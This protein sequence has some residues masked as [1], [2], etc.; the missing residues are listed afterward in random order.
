MATTAVWADKI[1]GIMGRSR[2]SHGKQQRCWWR[3]RYSSLQSRQSRFDFES[4]TE[5]QLLVR[6]NLSLV[7]CLHV[8]TAHEELWCR[9]RGAD[10]GHRAEGCASHN[11]HV[12]LRPSHPT[13]KADNQASVAAVPRHLAT[14][15]HR[16][17]SIARVLSFLFALQAVFKSRL[18]SEMESQKSSTSSASS[19]LRGHWQTR[20]LIVHSRH[21]QG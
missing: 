4:L 15:S 5:C 17:T 18:S 11:L 12:N 16:A 3:S 19:I 20:A 10:A 13:I 8:Q 1:G 6:W 9:R 21:L 7:A 14:H 2:D